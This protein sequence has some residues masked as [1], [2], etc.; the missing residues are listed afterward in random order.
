MVKGKSQQV[1]VDCDET[2]GPV[3]KPATIHTVLSIALSKNWPIH[4]L[5]VKNVFLHGDLK[6]TAYMH[7]PPGFGNPDMLHYVCVSENLYVALNRPLGLGIII[8]LHIFNI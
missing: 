5:D 4:Q 7:Q 6:E 3:V 8:L 2:F 1:G